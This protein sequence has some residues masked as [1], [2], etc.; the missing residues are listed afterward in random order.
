MT[1]LKDVSEAAEAVVEATSLT[2]RPE[3]IWRTFRKPL[4]LTKASNSVKNVAGVSDSS[5]GKLD[6][7]EAAQEVTWVLEALAEADHFVLVAGGRP[8]AV[9]KCL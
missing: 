8:K 2:L 5:M 9:W 3:G 6:Q 4:T 1:V 7:L